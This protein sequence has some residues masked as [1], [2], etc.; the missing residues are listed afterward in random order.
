MAVPP[1]PP[2]L[3]KLVEPRSG[4]LLF[5][6]LVV[7]AASSGLTD[8]VSAVPAMAA[9]LA[10]AVLA[11]VLREWV[12]I[13]RSR[14]VGEYHRLL[15]GLER[16]TASSHA[17]YEESIDQ[18]WYV[19]ADGR[20]RASTT[21]NTRALNRD[22]L[23]WRRVKLYA[24]ADLPTPTAQEMGLTAL[25]AVAGETEAFRLKTGA[26]LVDYVIFFRSPITEAEPRSWTVSYRWPGL[27]DPLRRLG[28]DQCELAFSKP[29]RRGSMRLVFPADMVGRPRRFLRRMPNAGSERYEDYEGRPS[30]VWEFGPC[31]PGQV[32]RADVRTQLT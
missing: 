27:W 3:R 22:S 29:A 7:A 32:F 25:E 12:F 1:M 30:L 4:P 26:G 23:A 14:D 13:E 19:E 24:T 10:L 16:A 20:D 31:L 17:E 2:K 8:Y 11:M 6:A 18:V 28:E 9:A 5:G 15:I 21:Y